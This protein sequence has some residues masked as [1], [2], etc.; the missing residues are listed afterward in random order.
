MVIEILN[1]SL[2]SYEKNFQIYLN[3]TN[4]LGTNIVPKFSGTTNLSIFIVLDDTAHSLLVISL[5]LL[6]RT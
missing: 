6:F 4:A 1:D 3:R 2:S 5:S